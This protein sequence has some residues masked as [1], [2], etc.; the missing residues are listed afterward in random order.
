MLITA[1][2]VVRLP[3]STAL[4]GMLLALAPGVPVSAGDANEGG[5]EVIVLLREGAAPEGSTSLDLKILPTPPL[6]RDLQEKLRSLGV[7]RLERLIQRALSLPPRVAAL[8]PA[9][10]EDP[11]DPE[12]LFLLRLPR[13]LPLE[14]TLEKLNTLPA[15]LYAEPNGRVRGLRARSDSEG[16]ELRP[17]EK[18]LVSPPNDPVSNW[19][20]AAV[21]AA[22]AWQFETGRPSVRIAMLDTGGETVHPDLGGAI[23][24][25]LAGGY[26]FV[27]G[28]SNFY[29]DSGVRSPYHG[30]SVAGIAA[31]LTNNGLATP[32]LC[33]GDGTGQGCQVLMPKILG[34]R[35][36]G[37]WVEFG[38]AWLSN[39]N[40][41]VDAIYWSL[42]N[43]ADVLNNSWCADRGFFTL[44]YTVHAAFRDA[45]I[46][47]ALN[48]G[49]MGNTDGECNQDTPTQEIPPAS[50]SDVVT[51]V[52]AV[53]SARNRV[54]LSTWQSATGSHIDLA[55]P[56]LSVRTLDL[57]GGS[58]AT[59]FF[60]G[61]SAATPFVSGAMGL[62][63]S[64]IEERGLSLYHFDVP[65]LLKLTA[66]DRGP[67]GF[68]SE[69][70]AGILDVGRALEVLQPPYV[71]ETGTAGPAAACND[72]SGFQQW[73]FM[74]DFNLFLVRRCE[75]RRQVSFS[76]AYQAAPLVWGRPVSTGGISPS[77]P[78]GQVT[79]TGV[80]PGTVT[81]TGAQLR[82]YVYQRWDLAGN[83]LGWYPRP[84]A[85]ADFAWAL[86]GI[87][88]GNPP[89][90]PPPPPS[91][92]PCDNFDFS[93]CQPLYDCEAMCLV[94]SSGP[95][96]HECCACNCVGDACPS[97]LMF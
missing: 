59:R 38:L 79:W 16:A 76:R 83:Y 6:D 34:D 53:D 13:G 74:S 46:R 25:K 24:W 8:V 81:T 31:G 54:V 87:P 69:Y 42:Q 94:G 77:N 35:S 96:G 73:V 30:M 61:T 45:Y 89:P 80:V 17:V 7:A 88:A 3:L 44:P 26:D 5:H 39:H 84:P 82:T 4:A 29:P 93:A 60:S 57:G 86:V 33:G 21:G 28:D 12:R 67:A 41:A 43:G 72:L 91:G 70:G 55:A 14:E 78:N 22:T 65:Y 75:V 49:A 18:V 66:A 68:D 95:I 19:G 27:H 52:G 90:P 23:G 11:Y 15:V 9:G 63:L 32:G 48:V 40:I 85:S 62:M 71:I 64:E 37:E 56:G 36:V 92:G 51:S 58:P 97:C 20:L 1:P 10:Y 50:Y 2:R 47:G